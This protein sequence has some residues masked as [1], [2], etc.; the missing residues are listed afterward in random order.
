MLLAHARLAVTSL[1]LAASPRW[2]RCVSSPRSSIFPDDDD[3]GSASSAASPPSTGSVLSRDSAIGFWSIY[4]DL[5]AS[6]ALNTLAAGGDPSS[7]VS[8]RIVLRA[9]GQT[10][11]GSD[12]PGGEWTLRNEPDEA[13]SGTSRWRMRLVLRSRLLRQE[14]RYEGLFFG[15][16]SQAQDPE[17]APPSIELRVVGQASRWDTSGAAPK[18][19]GSAGFSMLKMDVDR[20]KLTPTIQPFQGLATVDP[21]ELRQQAEWRKLKERTEEDEL[22]TAIEEV[23]RAKADDPDNW[24]ESIRL[25]EGIDYWRVGEEPSSAT[26]DFREGFGGEGG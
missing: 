24:Q 12:F 20:A 16:Q 9:D 11:R 4:D 25:R 10:S 3:G 17:Q 14:L 26:K 7:M 2:P 21:D 23:R 5:A 22:R 15:V 6:D 18:S 13:G 19:L 8:A 1:L